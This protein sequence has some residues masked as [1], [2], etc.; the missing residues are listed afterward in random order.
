MGQVLNNTASFLLS[1][2]I[3][4][5]N[6]QDNVLPMIK[7]L[8]NTLE[9]LSY[10]ILFIDDGSIDDTLKI[11]K[12]ASQYDN[13]IRFI[14]FTRNFGH[15]NALKAG[16]DVAQGDCVVTLD[17]DMQ[18]PPE[19]IPKMVMLWKDGVDIIQSQRMT[20]PTQSFFKKNSS[21]MYYKVFRFCSQVSL[22]SGASD[23]R[24]LD[25][26]V[27]AYCKT[28]T[29]D[30]FFWRGFIP[31]LG[32]SQTVIEYTPK[33]RLHGESKYS[34]VK[35]LRLAWSG[36]SSF[37]MLPL[38]LA[39]VFGGIGLFVAC[40]YIVYVLVQAIFGDTVPGWS[41]LMVALLFFGSV[42]LISLGILG[43]YMGKIYLQGKNR[44]SYVI[45][46]CTHTNNDNVSA[47]KV[48]SNFH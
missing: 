29:D 37:S 36:I 8:N 6:E 30:N 32:F 45:K 5:H 7:A 20:E 35:M 24:L 3:P 11:I 10:E 28:C 14:S 15:Q 38:R 44:P 26:K 33:A 4:V 47:K 22:I 25:K 41:S 21:S 40:I 1:V 34:I 19:F 13:R 48:T 2:I 42:Q 23:F 12:E 17:G 43:E 18:H 27:V 16:Y 31:W 9:D 39:S 46:E